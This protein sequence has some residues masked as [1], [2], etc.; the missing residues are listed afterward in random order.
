MQFINSTVESDNSHQC[1]I[2]TC[3]ICLNENPTQIQTTSCG[4]KYCVTCYNG[5][6]VERN[7]RTCPTCRTTQNVVTD[8]EITNFSARITECHI[9]TLINNSI[10]G[11][12]Y[13]M[14]NTEANEI[15][16]NI[17]KL[18]NRSSTSVGNI[19]VGSNYAILQ[20]GN[21]FLIG[22]VVSS[23]QSSW[24]ITKAICMQRNG[25][26]YP[27]YPSSRTINIQDAPIFYRIL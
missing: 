6:F 11:I 21:N 14:S 16:K 17:R 13:P 8:L 27:C 3:N 26:I 15:E 22:C 7:M 19:T 20:K 23:S 18:I 10:K 2:N 9:P 4:H 12:I 25:V 5:W 24:T 1:E